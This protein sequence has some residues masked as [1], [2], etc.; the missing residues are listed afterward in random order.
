[1]ILLGLFIC[2]NCLIRQYYAANIMD[3]VVFAVNCGG[4]VHTDTNGMNKCRVVFNLVFVFRYK[5]S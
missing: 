5:I 2:L 3:N 1:M 4:D